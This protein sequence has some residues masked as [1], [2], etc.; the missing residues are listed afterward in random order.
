MESVTLSLAT[1]RDEYLGGGE[2]LYA[3]PC[4]G[5]LRGDVL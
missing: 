1:Y 2:I 5:S 3:M 4:H